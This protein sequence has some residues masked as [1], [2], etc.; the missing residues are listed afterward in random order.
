MFEGE[1]ALE[2]EIVLE[3]EMMAGGTLMFGGPFALGVETPVGVAIAPIIGIAFATT[4]PAPEDV[5]DPDAADAADARQCSAPIPLIGGDAYADPAPVMLV[6]DAYE[7]DA[8]IVL[9][10]DA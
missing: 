1:M 5:V 7:Y 10:G 4:K 3:G 2:G 6:G 8:L 9:I